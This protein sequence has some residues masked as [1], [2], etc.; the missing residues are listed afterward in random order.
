MTAEEALSTIRRL[1]EY[2][3]KPNHPLVYPTLLSDQTHI[4]HIQVVWL[5]QDWEL[6]YHITEEFNGLGYA[7]EAVKAFLPVI[8][9]K[10]ELKEL[11]AICQQEN[12]AS[13]VVLEKSGFQLEHCGLGYYHGRTTTIS[14]YRFR[15]LTD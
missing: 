3:D 15:K 14:R 2:Y 13:R 9:D 7:Q 8:M 11:I 6:G 12:K 1:I 10:L 5:G 4:G